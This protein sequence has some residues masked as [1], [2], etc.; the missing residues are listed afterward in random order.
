LNKQG[1]AIAPIVLDSGLN[2]NATVFDW[3]LNNV[4]IPQNTV[5]ISVISAGNYE[6]VATPNSNCPQVFNFNVTALQPLKA[7]YTVSNDFEPNQT[8][9]V[10][11]TGGS[12]AYAYSFD[13]LPYQSN[14][15]FRVV[16]GGDILVKIRDNSSCDELSKVVT[17]WNYPRF[18]TPN[19][20]G[21]NDSWGI[22][23]NQKIKV[24]IFDRFG[25][26]LKQLSANERWNGIFNGNPILASD[27]WFTLYY[28]DGKVFEGHFSLKR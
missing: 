4:T 26:L 19:N 18:F 9:A 24:Y 11:A 12:G 6:L 22:K 8:I 23:S 2:L 27:Y 16:D 21:F 7:I 15:V 5:A 10:Q 14:S 20:D 3:K 13:N 28:S 25:K 1:N 17:L